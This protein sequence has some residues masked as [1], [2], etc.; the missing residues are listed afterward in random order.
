VPVRVSGP[1][2]ITITKERSAGW[3]TTLGTD[4]GFADVMSLGIDFQKDYAEM[5]NDTHSY[6]YHLPDD[7]VGIVGWIAFLE[8]SEGMRT[9]PRPRVAIAH[10]T[11]SEY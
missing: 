7:A 9:V 11:M 6:I 2:D 8:C 3:S 5:V 10:L 1:A 4:L